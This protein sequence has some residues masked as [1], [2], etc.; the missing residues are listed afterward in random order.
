MDAVISLNQLCQVTEAD[1]YEKEMI[2]KSIFH[3]DD[4]PDYSLQVL[5][6][7]AMHNLKRRIELFSI[8]L[9]LSSIDQDEAKRYDR[10]GNSFA[11][12]WSKI[13]DDSILRGSKEIG[14]LNDKAFNEMAHIQWLRNHCTA[15]HETDNPVTTKDVQAAALSLTSNLFEAQMPVTIAIPN[16][17]FEAVKKGVMS[18]AEVQNY[19]TKIKN[20][21]KKDAGSL[22]GFI[23]S[24]IRLGNSPQ[25]EN[26]LELFPY[27]WETLSDV[28]R[29]DI[30]KSIMDLNVDP[31]RDD[32]SDKNGFKRLLRAI[33]KVNGAHY[34]PTSLSEALF[35]VRIKQLLEAKNSYYGWKDEEAIAKDLIS[36]STKLPSIEIKKVFFEAYLRVTFGNYWGRSAAYSILQPIIDGFSESEIIC[37][38]EDAIKSDYPDLVDKSPRRYAKELFDSFKLKMQ[39]ETKKLEIEKAC[40]TLLKRYE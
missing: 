31:S 39:S 35:R 24:N 40:R 36:L 37:F 6:N 29:R 15:A 1:E 2:Q 19:G 26:S 22:N 21:S 27:L 11:E 5:W 10:D 3:I 8:D 7:A 32:S 13:K 9:F 18:E 16:D 30:G 25:Y 34:L 14:L 38:I 17:F 12:R 28:L 33:V 23:V 20:M 4:L